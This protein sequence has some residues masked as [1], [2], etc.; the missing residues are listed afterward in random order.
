MIFSKPITDLDIDD[1]KAFC[2]ECIKEGF[3]IDYK[4]DFSKDLAKTISAFANTWGGVILIG[5]EEERITGK[6]II[7]ANT[8]SPKGIPLKKGLYDRVVSIILGNIHPPLFPEI[9]VIPFENNTKAVI[10]V[11]IPESDK[12]PHT[13][14]HRRSVYVKTDSISEPVERA[15]IEQIEWLQDRRKKSEE[16]RQSLCKAA[17]ERLENIY[18]DKELRSSILRMDHGDL[19][20]PKGQ[21]IFSVVPLFPKEPFITVSELKKL[22]E[23][24]NLS[25]TDYQPGFSGSFPA[26][27]GVK[28]IQQGVFDYYFDEGREGLFFHEFNIYGLFFYQEPLVET[29]ISGIFSNHVLARLDQFLEVTAKFYDEIGVWG[30][31]EV[32]LKLTDVFG[33]SIVRPEESVG[34]PRNKAYSHQ[35]KIKIRRVLNKAELREK[36]VEILRDIFRE[37]CWAFNHSVSDEF[38]EGYLKRNNRLS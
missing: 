27:I 15:E 33:L 26:G 22:C 24:R 5:V 36:R 3:T 38:V 13:I 32:T 37:L 30:L 7:D 20:I 9:G 6:P 25:T 10:V 28:T 31:V 21:G 14:D 1:I 34:L 8:G 23:K 16:L 12:A 11:R 35:G 29:E 2:L 17:K 18:E 19:T 4:Q